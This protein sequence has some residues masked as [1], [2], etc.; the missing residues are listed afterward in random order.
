MKSIQL[1]KFLIPFFITILIILAC[2]ESPPTDPTERAQWEADKATA[3]ADSATQE[4]IA[5][6][7]Q[8]VVEATQAV[9]DA[10]QE[11]L[12]K[13]KTLTAQ[14]QPTAIPT[15]SLPSQPVVGK[16]LNKFFPKSHGDFEVVFVQEK[17]GFSEAKLKSK[18]NEVATLAITDL[19]SNP[20]AVAKFQKSNTSLFGYPSASS[21]SKGTTLLVG[22]RFQVQVR[23]TS[24]DFA[25]SDRE[26]WL[27]QF[28]LAGLSKLK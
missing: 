21:G 9:V 25:E 8:K 18:S 2:G 27:K 1:R 13:P 11:A 12:N 15:I 17:K 7:T 26:T 3:K 14:A 19:A 6:A 23:S 20:K 5:Q 4:A 16:E 28:D 22:S 24:N 10:T